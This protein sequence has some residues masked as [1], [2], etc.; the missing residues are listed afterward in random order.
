MDKRSFCFVIFLILALSATGCGLTLPDFIPQSTPAAVTPQPAA[1]TP[2][3]KAPMFLEEDTPQSAQVNQL[4]VWVP[5]QFDPAQGKAGELLRSHIDSFKQSNPD[6]QVEIRVKNLQGPAS[7]LLSLEKSLE[8]APAAAP[9]LV[10]L[11]QSDFEIAAR[12]NLIA[13]TEALQNLL[14]TEDWYDYARQLSE[15]QNQ[16]YGL[17]FA[18]DAMILLY[19]PSEL[20]M[21]PLNWQDILTN[22]SPLLFP[23][24]NDTGLFALNLYLSSGGEIYNESRQLALNLEIL[25]KIM[26][27]FAEGVSAD[28]FPGW[29]ADYETDEQVWAALQDKTTNMSISW[30]SKYLSTLPADI[31][32][33]TIPPLES[34]PVTLVKGWLWAFSDPYPERHGLS[35]RLLEHLTDSTFMAE[36][37]F[38]AGYLPVRPSSMT[39]WENQII[40]SLLSQ[41]TVSAVSVPSSETLNSIG[42]VLSEAV[43]NVLVNDY[44]PLEAARIVVDRINQE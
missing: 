18:A 35:L 41:A 39:A 25:E 14:A 3:T 2:T 13:P 29:L 30:T 34:E 8:I 6:V 38:E 42:P 27:F 10:L 7:M 31:A 44:L 28:T 15:F 24:G 1:S 43:Y 20:S 12:L 37:T 5:P 22:Q 26:S 23:A 21:P 32:A 11:P 17:P 36:W 33:T 4:I 19:R 9:A 16:P 40:N